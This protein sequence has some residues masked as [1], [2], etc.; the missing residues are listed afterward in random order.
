MA[1]CDLLNRYIGIAM[2]PSLHNNLNRLDVA[3]LDEDVALVVLV[4]LAVITDYKTDAATKLAVVLEMVECGLVGRIGDVVRPDVAVMVTD[5]EVGGLMLRS[6]G[7][8]W[9]I[10]GRGV[11]VWRWRNCGRHR[12]GRRAVA[13]LRSCVSV[14]IGL[15]PRLYDLALLLPVVILIGIEEWLSVR[16]SG[17]IIVN[18]LRIRP[19]WHRPSVVAIELWRRWWWLVVHLQL[20]CYLCGIVLRLDV[21]QGGDS[22]AE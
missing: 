22:K 1:E 7:P 8:G 18:V 5:V 14:R 11:L 19:R 10:L 17:E 3:H 9:L 2:L 16:D 12:K 6:C 13:V 21:C 15:R 20:L 4:A